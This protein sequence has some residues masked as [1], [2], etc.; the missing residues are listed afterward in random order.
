MS[1]HSAAGRARKRVVAI[2]RV[3]IDVELGGQ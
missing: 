3:V 2:T 1:R